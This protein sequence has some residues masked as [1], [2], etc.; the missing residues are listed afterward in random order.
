M[1]SDI[2]SS[3]QTDSESVTSQALPLDNEGE[4]SSKSPVSSDRDGAVGVPRTQVDWYRSTPWWRLISQS[5]HIS[6]R[7]S[8]LL[9]CLVAIG[10]SALIWNAC[11]V[12]FSPEFAEV[13][14]SQVSADPG[15]TI[16]DN[17]VGTA[18]SWAG[19]VSPLPDLRSYMTS[20]FLT[21]PWTIRKVA[22][23]VTYVLSMIAIWGFAGGLIAR[24]S[25]MEFGVRT[26]VG[27]VPSFKL[28][29]ARWR[30]IVW[31]ILMP[32]ATVA[33]LAL[34]PLILGYV[35]RAGEIGQTIAWLAA[36][37]CVVVM[38]GIGWIV[39]MAG[40]GFPLSVCAIVSEKGADAFDGLSR[41]AAYLFQRPMS[42][43]CILVVASSVGTLGFWVFDFLMDCGE[44]M[45]LAAMSV[46]FGGDLFKAMS[47]GPKSLQG[48]IFDS[49][50]TVLSSLRTAYVAS[51]FW[52][53]TAAAYLT[54]RW[55]IDHTDFDD[56]DLQEL[57]EPVAIPKITEESVEPEKG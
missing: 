22:F 46:G 17:P 10:L 35:A 53:A 18:W 11:L 12:C 16:D 23:S 38:L 34:I 26:S 51:F 6:W 5:V 19:S 1:P 13:V 50:Q 36:F 47:S 37:P 49:L 57:G 31:S 55:E 45:F 29:L 4:L 24:R 54:L 30:S 21:E 32:L 9:V 8:H 41:A 42:V 15:G 48:S 56:L 43:L 2:S 7:S 20:I 40:F 25:V 33:M 44:T 27:W 52:T 28:V 14:P 3:T 39:I